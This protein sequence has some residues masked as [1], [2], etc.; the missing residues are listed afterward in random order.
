[1]CYIVIMLLRDFIV[2]EKDW[3]IEDRFVALKGWIDELGA[4]NDVGFLGNIYRLLQ[5]EEK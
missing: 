4:T 2:L 5:E 1:M 3:V